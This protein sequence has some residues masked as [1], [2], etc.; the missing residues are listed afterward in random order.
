MGQENRSH[1]ILSLEVIGGFLDGLYLEFDPEMTCIIGGRGSGK[2]STIEFLR[3]GLD[4]MPDAERGGR[5]LKAIE[6]LIK[7]NLDTG[8]IRVRIETSQGRE[9]I[10]E[11][12][13][14]EAPHVL[15]DKGAPTELSLDRGALFGIDVYGQNEI[16]DIAG[17]ASFQL[18]LIDKFS[19]S[20]IADID[21]RIRGVSRHLEANAG[22]LLQLVGELEEL[23]EQIDELP[24]IAEQLKMAGS[25]GSKASDAVEREIAHK[26]LRDKEARMVRGAVDRL[27]AL[28][29]TLQRAAEETTAQDAKRVEKDQI[30]GPNRKIVERIDTRLRSL[31][32]EVGSLLEQALAAVDRVAGEVEAAG[33]NLRE[34]HAEQERRYREVLD[35]HAEEKDRAS[36]RTEL[37]RKKNALTEKTREQATKDTKFRAALGTRRHLL[38]E[39][40]GLRAE[41][42]QLR[43]RTAEFLNRHL[44]PGIRIEIKV[45]GDRTAYRQALQ[46]AFTGSGKRFNRWVDMISIALPPQEFARIINLDND[47]ESV[48]SLAEHLNLEKDTLQWIRGHLRRSRAI[49]QIEAVEMQDEPRIELLDGAVYK[50]SSKLSTGQKCTAVLPVLLMESERPLLVDQPE[51]NIDN[52]YIY[53]NVIESIRNVKRRRQLVFV[54]HNPNIPVLG[55]AGRIIVLKSDGERAS[56]L[57]TGSVDEVKTHV[58]TL[59]EGGEDAFR[60]RQKRYGY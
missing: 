60:M 32:P 2:S 14:G 56:V 8:R 11:R 24:A 54:T 1:R 37:E 58:A 7:G 15:D 48:E 12:R 25:S 41:R 6:G 50:D 10:V 42:S 45:F 43:R 55:E 9:Y 57:D 49:Y 5:R 3:F 29:K 16:E 13:F 17:T 28:R 31:A 40:G 59:L 4:V 20:E 44:S 46:E 22:E 35:K 21:R 38:E 51:D 26:G 39:L 30:E 47:G 33:N 34:Q 19:A 53:A 18:D 23:R 52:A 27:T 36:K